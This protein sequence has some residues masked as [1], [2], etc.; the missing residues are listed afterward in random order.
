MRDDAERALAPGKCH[1]SR[2]ILLYEVA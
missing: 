1:S 2:I